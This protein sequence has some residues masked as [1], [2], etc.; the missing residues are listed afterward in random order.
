M[1]SS[2]LR[3][4]YELF[5][6]FI[7]EVFLSKYKKSKHHLYDRNDQTGKGNAYQQERKQ[8]PAFELTV[9]LS[10]CKMGNHK[11]ARPP[12]RKP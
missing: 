12:R 9:R 4:R 2:Y 3:N 7:I 5:L 8:L 6:A 11:E 10:H 1:I